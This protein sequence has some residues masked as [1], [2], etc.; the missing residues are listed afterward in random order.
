MS[1]T[2]RNEAFQL[3]GDLTAVSSPGVEIPETCETSS[4]A[5][6]DQNIDDTDD[7]FNYG[8]QKTLHEEHKRNQKVID[9]TKGDEID[10]RLR[11]TSGPVPEIPNTSLQ[12]SPV[13]SFG[14]LTQPAALV[15]TLLPPKVS[16]T[17]KSLRTCLWKKAL[18]MWAINRDKIL[19]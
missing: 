7:W 16:S 10:S 8:R 11:S 1:E 18:S 15:T 9:L 13:P 3:P 17:S 19:A 4:A 12:M 2:I 14:T 6:T 5:F